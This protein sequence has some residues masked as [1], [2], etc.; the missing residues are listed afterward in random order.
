VEVWK[1]CTTAAFAISLFLRQYF[2]PQILNMTFDYAGV[3]RNTE[4]LTWWKIKAFEKWRMQK[5]CEQVLYKEVMGQC[6]I[7]RKQVTHL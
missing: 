6:G 5:Q 4:M 3:D 2:D 7:N 1:T